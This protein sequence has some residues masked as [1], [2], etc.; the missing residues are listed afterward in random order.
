MCIRPFLLIGIALASCK[1]TD[2]TPSA[3][4]PTDLITAHPWHVVALT[5]TTNGTTTNRFTD[6]PLCSRDNLLTFQRDQKLLT[7]EGPTK[8]AVAD[9][10]QQTGQWSFTANETQLA[11]SV[12][13]LPYLLGSTLA[14]SELTTTTLRLRY[15]QTGLVDYADI[16]FAAN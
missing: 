14:I 6:T 13:Y 7:D 9:P 5:T 16:T 11:G 10:Q 8:C 15:Q 12:P 4:S 2:S 1:K 3:T